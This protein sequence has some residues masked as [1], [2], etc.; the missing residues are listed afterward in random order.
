MMADKAQAKLSANDVS[1][2]APTDE[3]AVS[4]DSEVSEIDR[5]FEKK[6]IRK[7]DWW[8]VGFY[9]LVYIFRVIDSANYSNAAII[10]LEN[11]TGIKKQLGLNASQWAWTLSIFSY[12][13]LIFEPP[14]TLLMKTFRPSR[15]MFVLILG[16]GIS[17]CSSSAVMSFNGMMCA[18]FAIGL[19]E[20][21]F[22]PAVLFH[23]MA[24]WYKPKELPQR[25]A[26]FY[27]VGQLSS[28]LSGLL[29]YAIGF[30]DG[31]GGIPGWRWLFLLEGLPAIILAFIA[32]FWLPD[33]PE[34]SKLLSEEEREFLR[35][36]LGKA[37]PTG[38]KGH[39]DFTTLKV[40]FKDPSLYT[41]SIFW[42]CHGIGGFG[43]GFALPTVIYEL[44]FTTTSKSQLMN[45]PP[46]VVTF[47]FL[48]TV[49]Y[50]LHKK[51]IRPWTTAVAIE[52][53]TIICYIILITVP[54]AVV[55]YLALI[56]AVSC[57]GS[58]YPVIWPERIR[59]IEGTV[60]AGIGIGWT[61]A[62]AQFSGIVGPHVYNTNFGPTYR[63][64][65]IICL[66]FLI[67]SISGILASWT[68]VGRKDRRAAEPLGERAT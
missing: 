46:Y 43:V 63:T 47:L 41:F 53:T 34:T 54:N 45:I 25:V 62:M 49:G 59:A 36:R 35:G 11:G 52:S 16:W 60:A 37:A 38:K 55:K 21:G 19:A 23:V 67:G 5:E 7:I 4:S 10:N 39:W 20:A 32:L 26:I 61:N 33:Y 66:C 8:L 22:F 48:N 14:N 42:I 2:P 6:V 65:Y 50:L 64:S 56:V 29:A 44:G 51:I 13:Y 28:A 12:S 1:A 15:W 18:R 30:M 31:L 68:L 17:A 3:F 27:S 58:A 57:A 40:L 24:F 9:S